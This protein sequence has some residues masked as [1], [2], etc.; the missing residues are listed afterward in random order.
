MEPGIYRAVLVAGDEALCG[1]IEVLCAERP[2]R[3]YGRHA[4]RRGGHAERAAAGE[5]DFTT[6]THICEGSQVR[7]PVHSGFLY[8][9]GFG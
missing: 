8:A 2:A 4:G 3:T 5:R 9:S 7:L 6:R 1:D